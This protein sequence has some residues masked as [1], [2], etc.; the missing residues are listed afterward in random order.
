MSGAA[1]LPPFFRL[2]RFE[3]IDSTND[4]AMRLAEGG[5][6]E[7]TLVVAREQSAGRGR[8]GRS[9]V[10]PPGNLYCSLVLRPACAAPE[11]AQLSFA[12]SLAVA[13]AV[14]SVLPPHLAVSCKWPN[15]VLVAGA[16]VAGILLQSRAGGAGA[17]DWLVLG[18][19]VNLASHPRDTEYPATS[20]AA[21][22]AAEVTPEAMLPILAERLLAWYEAWR[23]PGGF[24]S[25]R[26]AWLAR[27]HGMGLPIRVRL[28]SAEI[29][30]RFAGLDAQ[31][32]LVLETQD[33]RRHI[34]AAEIFP[35]A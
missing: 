32:R 12:A 21:A 5:A 20:L 9:W 6:G 29:D 2:L 18:I 15:D 35:A 13:D 17:L 30:G 4:E 23:A 24:A 10:S 28:P 26:E 25:V 1:R 19:G 16:K 33:G 14:S 27:A 22:A 31:G 3:R 7:G 11:A 8:R 34:A